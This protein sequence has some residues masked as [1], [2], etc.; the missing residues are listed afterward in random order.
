MFYFV[1]LFLHSAPGKM[2]LN[3][4]RSCRSTRLLKRMEYVPR[5]YMPRGSGDGFRWEFSGKSVKA[6]LHQSSTPLEGGKH[7]S[8]S[9]RLFCRSKLSMVVRL[10][11]LRSRYLM[12]SPKRA[13]T[14]PG[15][16]RLSLLRMP[17]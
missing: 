13:G 15:C 5:N 9:R 2:E 6:R 14:S 3:H 11:E 1:S 7:R 12:R 17:T 16:F 8:A 10:L 4:Y